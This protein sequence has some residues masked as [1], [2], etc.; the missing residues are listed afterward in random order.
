MGNREKP[1]GIIV[2]ISPPGWSKV[3]CITDDP[4]LASVISSHFNSPAEYFPVMSGP[5]MG[6]P[7]WENDVI[8][9]GNTCAMLRTEK[10]ILAGLSAVAV[11]TFRRRMPD[12]AFVIVNSIAEWNEALLRTGVVSPDGVVECAPDELMW[13]VLL[14][15]RLGCKLEIVNGAPSIKHREAGR[16]R[17]GH[18]VMVDDMTRVIPVISAN[19][20]FAIDADL[21]DLPAV[22]F[23]QIDSIYDG[24]QEGGNQKDPNRRQRSRAFVEGQ[25]FRFASSIDRKGLTF[26]TFITRGM[27][28]GYFVTDLPTTH[29]YSHLDLGRH[30]ADS[31][32]Y[33]SIVKDTRL[34]LI[35]DPG[36]FADSESADV[37]SSLQTRNIKVREIQ[38]KAATRRNVSNY[39]RYYPYDLLYICTHAGELHEGKRL[40][41]EFSTS[42]GR[43]H[44]LVADVAHTFVP[45]EPDPSEPDPQKGPLIEVMRFLRFVELNGVA[46]T[47]DDGK[48]R[49]GAGDVIR[50]FTDLPEE[51]WKIIDSRDTDTI[52]DFP[53]IEAT[54]GP[55]PLV[56]E[57]FAGAGLARPIIFNNA[58]NSLHKL[59]TWLIIAGARAYI[60]T[61]LPVEDRLAKE[62]G[63]R[64]FRTLSSDKSLPILLWEV[65]Q[66]ILP[67]AQEPVYVH[68]GCHFASIQ[69]PD[70]DVSR[71]PQTALRR[72]IDGWYEYLA[73]DHPEKF[74]Q[75][76]RKIL[77][78]VERALREED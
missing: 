9:R 37:V 56:S 33:S 53:I 47:D 19:Y 52:R 32:Y 57:Y 60:G 34:A 18:C 31:I 40:T 10:I 4:I 65:Q 69:G 26:I 3:V 2:N 23:D 13:G 21:R 48:K 61:L 38:G 43:K 77:L 59:S 63:R 27:P 64:F 36:F 62:V 66:R 41:I 8:R 78:F 15:K 74:K 29:I 24:I 44:V 72:E 1:G 75:T 70:R 68:F 5:R 42:D 67:H 16:S 71:Y 14:A 28:Y 49:I 7:D 73:E 6:M 45:S 55:I 12:S 51:T 11:E 25:G 17:G 58:C 76:V 54:D 20:A 30:I 35:V 22:D 46:W 50:E 39:I